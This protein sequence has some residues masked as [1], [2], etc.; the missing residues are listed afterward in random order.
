M[1]LN[2]FVSFVK[3]Y[4]NLLAAAITAWLVAKANVLGLPGLDEGN[5]AT[6]IAGALAWILTQG[7]TQLGDLRWLRGHH[8][9]MQSDALVQ[10]AALTPA[11]AVAPI[12]T[13]PASPRHAA[14]M[15]AGEQ[16][17]SDTEE[18]GDDDEPE[19]EEDL[20]ADGI[21]DPAVLAEDDIADELENEAL[22]AP[23]E[24]KPTGEQAP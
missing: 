13:A 19:P 3:P 4:L 10:A 15:A 7:A 23:V 11:P 21:A 5:T 22:P 17:P 18:F 8:I 12:P 20:S 2:R 24:I 1:P 9:A 6:W 14:L 16:L